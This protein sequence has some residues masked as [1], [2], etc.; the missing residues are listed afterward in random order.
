MNVSRASHAHQMPQMI[1]AQIIPVTRLTAPK[2][3]RDLRDRGCERVGREVFAAPGKRHSPP[4]RRTRR[5]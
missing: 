5:S 4:S 1:R 3:R 2:T